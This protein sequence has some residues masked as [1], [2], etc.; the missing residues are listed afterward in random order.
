MKKIFLINLVVILV[1]YA[2][3][4]GG[5]TG[6]SEVL[7]TTF[8]N[9]NGQVGLRR[10]DSGD[11]FPWRLAVSPMG[12]IAL[13]DEANDRV[14]IFKLDGTFE[15]NINLLSTGVVFDSDDSLYLKAKFRKLN[16]DGTEAF[17]KGVGYHEIYAANGNIIGYD[18]A[19]KTYSIYSPTGQ[20]LK[21]HSEAPL[22]LG[23]VKSS[24]RLP[25]DS[26]LTVIEYS[27]AIYSIRPPTMLEYFTR[28]LSGFLYGVI[29]TGPESNQY[30]RVYKY[31]KC[32]K[33]LGSVDLPP[34]NI[35]VKPNTVP[36]QPTPD[37]MILAEYGQ[38]V[39]A[40]NGDV[41]T[42][43]RTPTKYAILKWTWVDDPSVP[44]GPDAPTNLAV[45]PSINGLYLTWTASPQDPGC[46]TGYDISRATSA[47]GVYSILTTVN[48]G[49]LKYNDT[50]ASAGTTFYY[51]MR[52]V[53]GSEY[54]TYTAEASGKR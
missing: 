36:P 53:S 26:H 3:V 30:Y 45:A 22:E 19:K 44:T 52:A 50:T 35:I 4:Y 46:V 31:N 5:F 21:T 15:R 14:V 47:G 9:G 6:P 43:K 11:E 12:R 28:D 1:A 16:K 41:Y 34:N 42:W 37:V 27:D 24:K 20:L 33:V 48:A 23:I 51:K 54:S 18:K 8:G 13:C 17:V 2:Q 25:D 7:S 40:S 49:V 39:I 10:G 38:P 32:G 29:I